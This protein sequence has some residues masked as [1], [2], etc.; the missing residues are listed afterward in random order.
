M[1]RAKKNRGK[2]FRLFAL[3]WNK[4]KIKKELRLS[5]RT[6]WRMKAEYDKLSKTE[7]QTIRDMATVEEKAKEKFIDYEF[8]Q[9]WVA[10]MKSDRIKSW[11][12]RYNNCKR[13][14]LILQKKN[15]ENWTIDDIKLRVIPEL[16]KTMKSI[17]EY[18]ISIR[19]LRPDMKL[20]DKKTGKVLSTKRE[21]A[22]P[23]FH[24]KPIYERIVE[25][26]VEDFFKLGNNS[27]REELLKRM[28]VTL[29]SREGRKGVGGILNAEW[30]RI[31]WSKKTID[32][33]ESKTGGGFYWLDCPLDLFGDTT[34]T[35][36][37]QYWLD[38]GKPKQGKIFD[39]CNGELLSDIYKRTA[40]ALGEPYGIGKGIVPHFARKLHACLLIER[41]VPLEMVA[42]DAPHGL[43]GVGW[44]DLSTLKKYYL[45][46]TKGKVQEYRQ[47]AKQL[48]I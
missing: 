19:S 21:K 8:V 2:V 6:Y 24:W 32:I 1:P 35:M 22:K 14:W 42:G 23:S 20:P 44:E 31:S 12:R 4:R 41:G 25:R 17:F 11:H 39:W 26:G 13:V 18:L 36:L 34:Y 46:F 28:H 9:R 45:A 48:N 37:R 16:R 30:G 7:K 33:F 3:N 15:P 10:L 29:G 43:F 40:K 27:D 47:K 5:E 38:R